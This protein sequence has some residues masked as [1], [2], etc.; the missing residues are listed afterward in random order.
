[1][2]LHSLPNDEYMVGWICALPVERAAAEAMLD[3]KHDQPRRQLSS[4]HNFYTLGRIGGH[5]VVI[6]CLPAGVYGTSPAATVATQ[7]QSSFE[8]IRIGLMVGIGG[9]IPNA[10]THIQLGDVVVSKPVGT[11]GGV[12]Q[13]DHGKIVE[14]GFNRTGSL[15]KPPRALLA[16]VSAME[17]NHEK[18][19][20]RISEFLADMVRKHPKMRKKFLRPGTQHDPVFVTDGRPLGDENTNESS[21]VTNSNHRNPVIHY[22]LI[23]SGNLVI[24]DAAARDRLREELGCDVLCFE[25]EAA[26]V[27]DTFPCVVIRGISDYADYHKNDL[28]QGYAAATA[29]ACAKELLY[30]IPRGG[31][32]V[33]LPAPEAIGESAS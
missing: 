7:M 17:T 28:W 2:L 3:E 30:I 8:R 25:M 15:N 26:G 21:G 4:D 11:F 6:T 23:A 14:D 24:K 9:G 13:Y 1:M 22:G 16:A 31:I 32:A 27:M 33:T 29:A 19:E 5:N 20:N 12:V 10:K 18:Q